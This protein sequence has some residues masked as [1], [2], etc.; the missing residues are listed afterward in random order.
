MPSWDDNSFLPSVAFAG[1]VGGQHASSSYYWTR[2]LEVVPNDDLAR[3][4]RRS[5]DDAR[6]FPQMDE[7]DPNADAPNHAC[8]NLM[9]P[10]PTEDEESIVTALRLLVARPH[11]AMRLRKIFTPSTLDAYGCYTAAGGARPVDG[12]VIDDKLPPRGQPFRP[13]AART[14]STVLTCGRLFCTRPS[15]STP[16]RILHARG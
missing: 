11:A 15:P 6:L 7:P 13:A 12:V 5:R 10:L 9:V 8:T 14:R 16:A 1:D 4:E 3:A 2:A